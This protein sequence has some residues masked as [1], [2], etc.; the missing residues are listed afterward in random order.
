M[1][2][3]FQLGLD[4]IYENF[5]KTPIEQKQ[6]LECF[7]DELVKAIE[8]KIIGGPILSY[9][10]ETE[11]GAQE[12]WSAIATIDYSHVGVHQFM[13]SKQISIDIFSCK[14]YDPTVVVNLTQKYFGG[15]IIEMTLSKALKEHNETL[16]TT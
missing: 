15:Q 4:I 6:H 7:L 16:V 1:M 9:G 12:G 5:P 3:R 8:M 10:A 11:D 13:T 2:Q 14:A